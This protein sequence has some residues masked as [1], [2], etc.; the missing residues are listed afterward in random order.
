MNKQIA[1]YP[2]SRISFSYQKAGI[3]STYYKSGKLDTLCQVKEARHNRS[4]MSL[5]I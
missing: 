3:A 2:Y 1:L 4:H 5:A